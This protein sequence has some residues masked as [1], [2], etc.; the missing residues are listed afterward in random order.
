[1]IKIEYVGEDDMMALIKRHDI[2]FAELTSDGKF[3]KVM[4]RRGEDVYLSLN[5]VIEHE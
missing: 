2:F 3:Y 5:E 1:M 4:N